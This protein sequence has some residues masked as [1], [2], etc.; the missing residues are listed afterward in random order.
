MAASDRQIEDFDGERQTP[1]E[2]MGL[3][4]VGCQCRR[5]R[6]RPPQELVGPL[7]R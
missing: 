3:L 6:G 5:G 1:L 4:Q 7:Q 2:A